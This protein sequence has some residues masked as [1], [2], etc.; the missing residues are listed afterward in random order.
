LKRLALIAVL[1]VCAC[2]Q[3]S[4]LSSVGATNSTGTALTLS[5]TLDCTPST[6][7]TDACT[8]KAAGDD[9]TETVADGGTGTA[10]GICRG[11]VDGAGLACAPSRTPRQEAINACTGKAAGDLCQPDDHYPEGLCTQAGTTLACVAARAPA[12]TAVTACAT[13]A[14]GDDCTL[15]AQ[16]HD[17]HFEAD[18]GADAG[19]FPGTCA[20]V[21]T[22]VADAGTTVIACKPLSRQIEACMG[23]AIGA[24]CT[25]G[26]VT[27]TCIAPA[28]G[29]D[30]TCVVPCGSAFFGDDFGGPD[31]HRGFDCDGP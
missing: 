2:S 18:A 9:C 1:A 25:L 11:T 16:H 12:T 10:S 15:P 22:I 21:T 4:N 19:T 26:N 24:G 6:A 13:L 29:D 30:V 7:Q 31:G 28:S 3:R 23:V 17:H 8:G 20:S 5:G 27:G 14:A